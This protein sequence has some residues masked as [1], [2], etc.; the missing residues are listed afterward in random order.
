[1]N[2]TLTLQ[3]IDIVGAIVS[4]AT[5]EASSKQDADDFAEEWTDKLERRGVPYVHV[6][7]DYGTRSWMPER[8]LYHGLFGS[9][10]EAYSFAT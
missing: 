4:E 6:I 1:M 5:Y 9:H 2:Y 7:R 10:P 3:A 8:G